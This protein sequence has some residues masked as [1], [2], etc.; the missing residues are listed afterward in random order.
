V[1]EEKGG[2]EQSGRGL[3][4]FLL[5]FGQMSLAAFAIGVLIVT[6]VSRLALILA[7]AATA[8]TLTSRLLYH[9][10]RGPNQRK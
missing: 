7:I 1:T 5:G 6:G 3:T 4:R 2:V 9:G 8:L 10:R